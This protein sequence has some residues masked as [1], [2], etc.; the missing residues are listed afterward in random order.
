MLSEY[1]ASTS[2]KIFHYRNKRAVDALD[3]IEQNDNLHRIYPE[4]IFCDTFLNERCITHKDGVVFYRDDDHLSSGGA[5]LVLQEIEK[6]I[7]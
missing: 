5:K 6:F 7:Q 4:R 3:R 1:T 2:H